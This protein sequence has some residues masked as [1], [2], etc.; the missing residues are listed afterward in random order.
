MKVPFIDLGRQHKPMKKELMDA[1][2]KVLDSMV[3]PV[4]HW[5]RLAAY[6][7]EGDVDKWWKSVQWLMFLESVQPKSGG[8]ISR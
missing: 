8:R 3:C 1:F 2:E 5:V 7:V 6:L 4:E